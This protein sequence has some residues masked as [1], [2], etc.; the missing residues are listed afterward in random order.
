MPRPTYTLPEIRALIDSL[1][2]PVIVVHEQKLIAANDGWL[3]LAGYSREEAEGQ[4]VISF[5]APSDRRRLLD[6]T[7]R[8]SAGTPLRPGGLASRLLARDGRELEVFTQTS[9]FPAAEGEPFTV[10]VVL[11]N[12][13]RQAEH[14]LAL[15]LVEI[16]TTLVAARTG[17]EVRRQVLDQL[18]RGRFWAGFYRLELDALKRVDA[19]GEAEMPLDAAYALEALREGRPCYHGPELDPSHVFLPLETRGGQELLVLSGRGLSHSSEILRL[20]GRLVSSA[21]DNADDHGFASRQLSD[22]RLM[23]DLARIT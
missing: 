6:R 4:P 7:V 13:G 12:R 2:W 14:D 21:I 9:M 3:E 1:E 11:S 20:F 23:L 10:I 22:T 8:R 19:I 5:L 15:V 17:A 18:R 16:A